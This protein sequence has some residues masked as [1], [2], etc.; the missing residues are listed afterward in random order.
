MERNS[1]VPWFAIGIL[2]GAV[3]GLAAGLLAAPK[4]GHENR[5]L[6][7]ERLGALQERLA[8]LRSADGNGRESHSLDITG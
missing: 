5:T 8:K 2:L 3:A 1:S 7:R 6:V 4:T